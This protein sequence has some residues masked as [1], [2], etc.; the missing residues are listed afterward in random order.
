MLFYLFGCQ[1][2]AA[3]IIGARFFGSRELGDWVYKPSD[4]WSQSTQIIQL[5]NQHEGECSLSTRPHSLI[6]QLIFYLF[7]SFSSSLPVCSSPPAWLLVRAAPSMVQA[8]Q[9]FQSFALFQSFVTFQWC[10]MFPWL[11]PFPLFQSIVP[12]TS[13]HHLLSVSDTSDT[14]TIL[15]SPTAAGWSRRNKRFLNPQSSSINW[16]QNKC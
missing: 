12:P 16:I 3:P 1:V 13:Q 15:P 14:S 6:L 10:V 8:M 5:S 2:E 4:L 7:S 11:N 9:P